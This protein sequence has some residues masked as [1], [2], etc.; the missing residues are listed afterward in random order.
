MGSQ[1]IVTHLIENPV[2]PQVAGSGE[3]GAD[4]PCRSSPVPSRYMKQ[5]EISPGI[6]VSSGMLSSFQG[7]RVCDFHGSKPHMHIWSVLQVTV[8]FPPGRQLSFLSVH[9]LVTKEPHGC[10]ATSPWTSSLVG[11]RWLMVSA[12]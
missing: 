8:L 1:F 10:P 9:P 7:T 11:M 4:C 6:C 12:R 2:L 5:A 3:K